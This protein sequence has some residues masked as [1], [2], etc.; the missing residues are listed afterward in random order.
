MNKQNKK[1]HLIISADTEE[2]FDEMKNSVVI[3]NPSK[4]RIK[5]NFLTRCMIFTKDTII[6]IILNSK[7]VKVFPLRITT[8]FLS[9]LI[10]H[11]SKHS[12]QFNKMWKKYKTWQLLNTVIFDH[13][14]ILYVENPKE[15]VKKILELITEFT[16]CCMWGQ[17]KNYISL[18]KKQKEN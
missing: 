2:A 16:I 10:Q 7:M 18:Y 9:I 11:C 6:R 5:I 15:S 8:I 4:I 14:V 17:Y 3:Y 12:T 1:N 13:G